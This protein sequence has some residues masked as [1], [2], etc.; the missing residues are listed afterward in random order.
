MNNNCAKNIKIIPI[1]QIRER[2]R[3][4]KNNGSN[5]Y[6]GSTHLIIDQFSVY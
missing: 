4:K 3:Q 2:L 1:I 6:G 5:K